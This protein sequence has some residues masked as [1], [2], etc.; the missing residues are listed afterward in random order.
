MSLLGYLGPFFVEYALFFL[1][2]QNLAAM[3]ETWVRYLGWEDSL[4]KGMAAHT[5]ILDW[6]I[7]WTEEPNR[8]L[9][10]GL[11]SVGHD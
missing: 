6:R 10:M 1:V 11:K 9:S 3:Q 7:P 4:E 5:G 8:V 2:A